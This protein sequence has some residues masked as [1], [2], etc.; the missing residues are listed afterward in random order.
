MADTLLEVANR[1]RASTDTL[2]RTVRRIPAA[3]TSSVA[4]LVAEELS[5]STIWVNLL[6]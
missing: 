5:K 4:K 1:E 3:L 2:D 6:K